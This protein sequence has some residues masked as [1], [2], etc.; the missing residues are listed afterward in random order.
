MTSNKLKLFHGPL[1]VLLPLSAVTLFANSIYYPLDVLKFY[2]QFKTADCSV[3]SVKELD[4]ASDVLNK[5]FIPGLIIDPGISSFV[6][7]CRCEINEFQLKTDMKRKLFKNDGE[8]SVYYP[9][10]VF[11]FHTISRYMAGIDVNDYSDKKY[12][13]IYDNGIDLP[14][15]KS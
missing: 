5:L 2:A 12:A 10:V 15:K 7:T 4:K 11:R 13:T 9:A 6:K 14:Q 3:C 1:L 8:D